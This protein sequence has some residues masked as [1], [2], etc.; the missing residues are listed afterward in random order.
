[1][2]REARYAEGKEAEERVKAYLQASGYEVV[3]SLGQN[4]E[5]DLIARDPSSGYNYGIEVKSIWPYVKSKK[6]A[7]RGTQ[8]S[9]IR[10]DLSEL[11]AFKEWGRSN[12]ATIVLIVEV[13]IPH[14]GKG[15][16]Y[17]WVFPGDLPEPRPSVTWLYVSFY[18][19]VALAFDIERP[20]AAQEVET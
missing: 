3:E 19:L 14:S 7:T 20:G 18:D 13:R 4:G 16:L 8:V 10:Y 15:P 1:M 9:G 5:P 12:P 2:P 11:E 6:S 17:L